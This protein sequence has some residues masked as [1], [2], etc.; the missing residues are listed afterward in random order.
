MYLKAIPLS[1][2]H[3]IPG[4]SF[5]I[6]FFFFH[7]LPIG[8]RRSSI[9]LTQTMYV[10]IHI[11]I[12]THAHARTYV[13]T[14]TCSHTAVTFCSESRG[15]LGSEELPFLLIEHVRKN[16]CGLVKSGCVLGKNLLCLIGDYPCTTTRSYGYLIMQQTM[17]R[18]TYGVTSSLY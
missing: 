4:V 2:C 6:R 5:P 1:C 12:L 7:Q 10:R 3:H 14:C 17:E 16:G 8:I 9:C 13:R 11:R 15:S 18:I